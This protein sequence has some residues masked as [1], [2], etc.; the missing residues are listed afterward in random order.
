[1]TCQL[2]SPGSS[3]GAT[4][5][6]SASSIRTTS[7]AGT[8]CPS[9]REIRVEREPDL[10]RGPRRRVSIDE[11]SDGPA[12]VDGLEERCRPREARG[13]APMSPPRS[14]RIDA[15]V[16]SPEPL[17]G[18]ADR[19]CVEVRALERDESRRRS[20][21]GVVTAHHAADRVRAIR[22]RRSRACRARERGRRRRACGCARRAVPGGRRSTA[23]T[24]VRSRRHASAARARA[25]R[26]W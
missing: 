25:S 12:G 18:A 14:K 24:G 1:M 6:P 9:R 13:G 15:S 26:S 22:R 4:S 19:R 21:L 7:P 2:G 17:A 23:Q 10:H 20:D 16:L 8:A 11:R 5:K 3:S